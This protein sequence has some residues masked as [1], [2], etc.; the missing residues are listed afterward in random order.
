MLILHSK[1]SFNSYLGEKD[2][3]ILVLNFTG[4]VYKL[5]DRQAVGSRIKRGKDQEAE[6]IPISN[7]CRIRK[8]TDTIQTHKWFNRFLWYI[9]PEFTYIINLYTINTDEIHWGTELF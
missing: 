6:A 9:S 1:F 2:R 4:R 3:G 7:I 8:A 5:I